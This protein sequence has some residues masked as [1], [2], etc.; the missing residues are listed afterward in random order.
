[1]Q[2]PHT[3][4][5]DLNA[6]GS[7]VPT[8]RMEVRVRKYRGRLFIA[9]RD[10]AF[11]LNGPAEFIFKQIDGTSTLQQIAHRIADRYQVKVA[12]A[13]ADSHEFLTRLSAAGIIRISPSPRATDDPSALPLSTHWCP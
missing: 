3:G 12:E 1:M 6:E 11:E 9:C 4:G 5:G 10:R 7:I 8:R 2:G 13:M